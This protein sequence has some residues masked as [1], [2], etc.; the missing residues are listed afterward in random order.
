MKQKERTHRKKREKAYRLKQTNAG[1]TIH[2][3][4]VQKRGIPDCLSGL[5]GERKEN[6]RHTARGASGVF[7]MFMAQRILLYSEKL[8]YFDKF[9]LILLVFVENLF[10]L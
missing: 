8:H 6:V 4:V 5:E 10:K 7:Y 1:V 3:S 2:G 9:G